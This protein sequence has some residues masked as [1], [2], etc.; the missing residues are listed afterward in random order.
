MTSTGRDTTRSFW[1]SVLARASTEELLQMI[2][3]LSARRASEGSD[4][5]S[6]LLVL[7]RCTLRNRFGIE[8]R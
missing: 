3:T 6:E 2:E 4:A 5:D 7:A 1:A 8:A